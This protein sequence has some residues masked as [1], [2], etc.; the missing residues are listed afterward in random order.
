MRNKVRMQLVAKFSFCL[1]APWS[2]EPPP[3]V[4]LARGDKT[5]HCRPTIQALLMGGGVVAGRRG[6]RRGSWR[7]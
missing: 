6:W 7:G 3:E 1:H 4:I 5:T 2:A